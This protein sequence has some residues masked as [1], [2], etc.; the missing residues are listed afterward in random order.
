ME[1]NSLDTRKKSDLEAV[2]LEA[3]KIV[4]KKYMTEINSFP[5]K[6][7]SEELQKCYVNSCVRL[8]KIEKIVYD[9]NES[10]QDKL[11]NV[12]NAVSICGGSLINLII[13][14]G[15]NVDY[16]IG[17][18]ASDVNNVATCQAT[19]SG[20]FEGNFP[21]SRIE[22]QK[23]TALEDSISKIF[24]S[25]REDKNRIVSV[26][27]GIPGLRRTD[28]KKESFMQGIEKIIDSMRG[29]KYAIV[30]ISDPIDSK[31]LIQMKD[32]YEKIYSQLSPFA[33][34]S[35]SYSESDSNA[36]AETVTTGITKIIGESLTDTVSASNSTGRSENR[37]YSLSLN[38]MPYGLGPSVSTTNGNSSSITKQ[39]GSSKGRTET[40]STS[41]SLNNGKTD[42][43]TN[44]N[45]RSLQIN[46]ENRKVKDLMKK[47]EQ[48]IERIDDASDVGL[49]NTA[50]YCIA[51]DSQTSKIVASTFESLCRGDKTSIES[52][53]VATWNNQRNLKEI[54]AYLKKFAHP[55][56]EMD[57]L[58]ANLEINPTSLVNGKE[59]V[60][61]AGLPQK[62]VNGIAV[63]KMARFSR[64]IIMEAKD[65]SKEINVGKIYHMGTTEESYVNLE[66]Q[67]LTSHTFITGSTG[68]GKSN[69]IYNIINELNKKHKIP[70]LIIEPAKG[71]YKRIF[72]QDMNVYGTNPNYTELLSVN[73]FKFP[74]AIHVL[75]HIDRIIDIFNVCWPMY[76]AMPAVLKDAVEKAYIT[77]G[78]DLDTSENKY[79]D[80]MFPSFA[81]VLAELRNVI[82]KSDFSQEVKDNYTGSLITRV[83]SLTNGLNGRIFTSREIDNCK[84]FDESTIVDLSRV[85]SP[86]TKAMIM[87]IL[88]MKL[89]EHRISQG[90]MN[91]PLKHITVLEEAHNLL[92]R[93][94]TEQT[95]ESSN[96]LGKS[97]EML[98]N[99]IA[100]IRSYGEGFIIADQAPGL[101]DLSVIRNTNTK[102]IL[103]LPDLSDRELVGKAAGLN[104]NQIV[105]LSKLPTGVAAVYQN[106]WLEP[107]LCKVNYFDR[108]PQEYIFNVNSNDKKKDIKAD[109]ILRE[110]IIQ[111]LL[112]DI[113]KDEVK[114]DIEKL[115]ERL[116][117]T[118]FT[119]GLKIELYNALNNRKPQSIDEIS[120]LIYK[121]FDCDSLF[122]KANRAKSIPEWNGMLLDEI[123]IETKTISTLCE[124]NLLQCII[125]EKDKLDETDS[126]NYEK[127][128]VYMGRRIQ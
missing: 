82:R 125:K 58:D 26:V 15:V 119:A 60:I 33:T 101:L 98:A 56:L 64:N 63:A 90:G 40:K 110:E 74:K 126:L 3:D 27:T 31:K 16:Y 118:A 108:K 8:N 17:V 7:I 73:P 62:S 9:E 67:S 49:W 39:A 117:G 35:L 4:M 20:T 127:W 65:D 42:T 116:T 96:L 44:S 123:D 54:C 128:M 6:P 120:S 106:Q 86:E 47:I 91:N 89:E 72:G 25:T 99:T 50:T 81:D 85:G 107:V 121:C 51:D 14:D 87:G 1:I 24:E 97:V 52:Y 66:L 28:N 34:T 5:I 68:S 36:V 18:K 111:Y 77:A 104:D 57:T 19:L 23:K 45:G 76:A 114:T 112:S 46:F 80:L 115:K 29:Q 21:G 32:S 11:M 78:W 38:L 84:L 30:I 94:S 22:L 113:S 43:Y 53:T 103:R 10:N 102:I 2:F 61:Q 92:K 83:K 79:N 59:L 13:S 41:D 88:I 109:K 75:E 95:S 100:E 122:E 48:Q 12:Y 37:S 55:V 70:T 105:E 71:E 124:Q 93:T 69:T